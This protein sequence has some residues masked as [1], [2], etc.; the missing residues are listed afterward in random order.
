M[1]ANGITTEKKELTPEET[2]KLAKSAN[3][4]SRE[5]ILKMFATSAAEQVA[6]AIN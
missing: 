4:G 6:Q 1:T 2:G 5:D 3:S